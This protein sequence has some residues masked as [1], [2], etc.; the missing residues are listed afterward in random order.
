MPNPH[1]PQE[2]QPTPNPES[3]PPPPPPSE[4]PQ[5][6]T[7]QVEPNQEKKKLEKNDNSSPSLSLE[8]LQ[9]MFDAAAER[10][11]KMTVE[12]ILAEHPTWCTHKPFPN[13]FFN[14]FFAPQ[15]KPKNDLEFY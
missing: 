9:K 14:F 15:N 2:P 11:A 1:P 7:N 3:N 12:E 4:E 6:A 5:A 10:A 8:A 13:Y